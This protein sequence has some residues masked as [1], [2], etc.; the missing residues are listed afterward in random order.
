MQAT[1]KS[2]LIENRFIAFYFSFAIIEIFAELISYKPILFAFKPFA[3]IVLMSLYWVASKERNFLFFTTIFF[4]LVSSI[5]IVIDPKELLLFGVISFVIHRVV[6]ILYIIKLNNIKDFKPILIA[7]LPF[8]F[9]FSYLI[10]ISVEIPESSY[11]YLVIQNILVSII[12]GIA[13]SNYFMNETNITPWL[14]IFGLMSVGLYFIV[15]LEK[16]FLASFTTT[17]FR[18]LGMILFVISYFSFY[19]FVIDS[20][21]ATAKLK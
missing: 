19:K 4:S 3:L 10:S 11:Y 2:I 8:I 18:P 14:P 5:L 7:F 12:G 9:I 20:E 16:W 21:R 17:Y 15:F 6:L 13:V 1:N